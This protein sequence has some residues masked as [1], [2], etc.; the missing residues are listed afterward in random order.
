MTLFYLTHIFTSVCL[1]YRNNVCLALYKAVIANLHK[2]YN[3]LKLP[4]HV[5][6]N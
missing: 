2:Y 6:K 1:L 3:I 5:A 4:I